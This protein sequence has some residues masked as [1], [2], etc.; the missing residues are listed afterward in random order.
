MQKV[1][2]PASNL[3]RSPFREESTAQ[4]EQRRWEEEMAHIERIL[5]VGGG[6]AGLT[7]ATALHRHGLPAELVERSTAWDV[8]G[9]ASCC[10]PTECACS[11][12]LA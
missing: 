11:G 8:T 9:A 4:A 6:I 1:A 12:R 5:I 2:Q 7:L 10:M 3:E